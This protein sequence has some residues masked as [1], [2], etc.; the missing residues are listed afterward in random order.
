MY[1]WGDQRRFNSYAGYIKH[2]FGGRV[3]K[4]TIDAGF[5][6]PNRDGSISMG[7]CAY[8]NNDSFNPSYCTPQKSIA[9]QLAEGIDFH[10]FRYRRVEKYLAYFQAFS[11][12]YAPLPKLKELYSEALSHENVVGLVIGTRPDCVDEQKLDY[13]AE[14]AKDY[15]VSIEYGVESCYNR[16][17]EHINRGHNFERSVWAIEQTA[18]RGLNVGAHFIIGLPG[19]SRIDL[20]D[21]TE[22]ISKLPLTTI[23]FHQL[24]IV[25][26]T[27]FALEYNKNPDFFNFFSLDEYLELMVEIIERLNPSIVIERFTGEASPDTLIAPFWGKYRTDQLLIKLEK[28][29]EDRDTWQ[30]KMYR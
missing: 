12:T 13:L 25:K 20:V 3:Q 8:C 16:T 14:L 7:G 15:Y 18:K 27:A 19:E 23:K 4:L 26:N 21:Q 24:Q 11:N 2:K 10:M 28:M 29:L 5:T 9:Q 22:I 30:G 1:P 6:C 17:L